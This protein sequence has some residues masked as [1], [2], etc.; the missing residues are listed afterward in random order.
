MSWITKAESLLNNLDK[1]AGS[2]LQQAQKSDEVSNLIEPPQQI[3]SS[4]SSFNRNANALILSKSATPKKTSS[5]KLEQDW[6]SV[7]ENSVKTQVELHDNDS[8]LQIKDRTPSMEIKENSSWESFSVEKELASTK[9]LLSE[10]RS[11]NI[12]LK[13]EMEA[14]HEQIKSDNN[15]MKM[16]DLEDLCAL[17]TDEKRDFIMMNQSFENANA[18]YIKT[19]SEL[20][21]NI[22]NFQ[23]SEN[24]LKQKLD[25]AKTETKDVRQELLNYKLRA[26]NQ[27]QMKEKLIEQ[28]KSG[29][30]VETE[31]NG[32]ISAIQMESDQLRSERDHLQT[33]LNSL[34]KRFEET[35]NF[36]EK[37]EHKHRI[38]EAAAEDK[39]NSLNET[40]N[41]QNLK[42]VQN[43]D[44][45]RLQKEEIVQV[46]EE[47]LSQKKL[48]TLK[49]HDKENELKRLKNAYRE[50][51]ANSEI[52]NRVQSLTQSLISK[53]NNLEAITAER[54]ALKMQCEKI[55][56]TIIFI[57]CHYN[58]LI[59]FA[60]AT[61]SRNGSSNT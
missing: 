17:L 56:V 60:L 52:E 22:M 10:V 33:E 25:F 42:S 36:I 6:D 14:L 8:F 51:Q 21:T 4:N 47:M 49:L 32:D 54:N 58:V 15:A 2:V 24:E 16:K 35:R 34:S 41:Q 46:R 29:A 26:Q 57:S 18:K 31:I 11:E 37:L 5:C 13:M 50:T 45:I 61:T 27:L 59:H 19:I 12:E 7:S 43:E 55:S 39:I 23:R 30:F 28:L 40:L 1:K 9:I 44:E 48:M 53:Q 38:M 3:L 20:E